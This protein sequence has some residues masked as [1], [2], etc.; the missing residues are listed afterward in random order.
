MTAPNSGR[1]GQAEPPV[2]LVVSDLHHR[3]TGV[4]ATIRALL[5]HLRERYSL[6]LVSPFAAEAVPRLTLWQLWRRLRQPLANRPFV[7]WHARR[8]NELFWALL[9]RRVLRLPVRVVFTSAA[10]RR[11]SWY[12]RQLIN[13]VDA[14]IATSQAAAERVPHVRAV[15][16]HGVDVAR[17]QTPVA[18]AD[19]PWQGFQRVVGIVGRVRPEKGTDLFVQALCEV[20]PQHN[21]ACAVVVGKTT[22]KYQRFQADLQAQLFAAGIDD[23][24][25]FLDEVAYAEMPGI[26]QALDIVCAPARYE[27]YGLVPIEAMCSG[28]A[29]VASRTGAYPD[30]IADGENG[31]L[32]KI[33]DAQA[34]IEALGRLLSDD[35]LLAQQKAA[36]QAMVAERFSIEREVAGVSAV[37]E[38]L[39]AENC[40]R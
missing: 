39:W 18:V 25:F 21:D 37:Y 30:M 33:G 23:R 36:S 34:L 14:V 35:A 6:V 5:P 11:H 4:S 12:P 9:A 26:Y 17:F 13:A 15:V 20:L 19:T 2:E 7:V 3:I 24:V 8:N 31:F 1:Q 27:G 10:I 40:R 32:T 28:T 38:A 16:P 29:V 22:A